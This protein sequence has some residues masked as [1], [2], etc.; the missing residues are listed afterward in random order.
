M[1]KTLPG[2]FSPD[3]AKIRFASSLPCYFAVPEKDVQDADDL[4]AATRWTAG[5]TE[6]GGDWRRPDQEQ[7]RG[8][9]GRCGARSAVE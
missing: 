3:P 7:Q 5:E 1:R 8:G 4:A 9:V 6:H 2:S